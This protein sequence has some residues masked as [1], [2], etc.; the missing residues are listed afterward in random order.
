MPRPREWERALWKKQIT[1]VKRFVLAICTP[2]LA[3]V[4][5]HVMQSAELVFCDATSSLD[6]NNFSLFILSTAHPAGGLPLG[7][8]VTS[9][10]SERLS[11]R[12]FN[13]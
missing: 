1:Q 4:H 9:D 10:E 6:R 13:C 7:V 3:R 12:G 11:R 5:E 2:L 8:V